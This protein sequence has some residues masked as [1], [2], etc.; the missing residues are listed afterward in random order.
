[1]IEFIYLYITLLLMSSIIILIALLYILW[2]LLIKLNNFH[3]LYMIPKYRIKHSIYYLEAGLIKF[4]QIDKIK[5]EIDLSNTRKIFYKFNN[6]A[7]WIGTYNVNSKRHKLV[8]IVKKEI[9]G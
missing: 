1:M 4:G 3:K 9:N 7:S 2:K 8:E 6:S 5:F